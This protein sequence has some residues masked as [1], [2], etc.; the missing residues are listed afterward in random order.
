MPALSPTM[1]TGNIGKWLKNEGDKINAGDLLVEVQT[2]KSTLE[3]EFPEEGYLAKILTPNGSK[4]V[5]LGSPI[6]ILVDDASKISSVQ[7]ITLADLGASSGASATSAPS[8][9]PSTTPSTPSTPT[10]ST[11]SQKPKGVHEITMPMLSPTMTKGRIGSWVKQVGDKVSPGD[12]ICTV[13]TDKATVDFEFQEEGYLAKIVAPQGT[14]TSLGEVIAILV[15]KKEDL[16]TGASYTPSAATAAPSTQQQ[17]QPQQQQQPQSQPQVQPQQPTSIQQGATGGRIFASPLAK[18]VAAEKG[19]DLREIGSGSGD[20]GRIIRAD[21]EE[22]LMRKPTIQEQPK[23]AAVVAQPQV[24]QAGVPTASYVDIPVSTI[25]KVIAER[26]TESKR[27]IPHYYLTVEIEVDKLLKAREEL[28][29][30]GEKR[31]FK[32]SVNDMLVKAAALAMKKAPEV[33]SSW[34][35]SFIRQYN[36]VDVSVAVQTDN[37]LITPIV[38]SAESKGLAQI[39]NEIKALAAKARENKLK[40]QEFQGGTFTI[41]NLGMFGIDEFSAIINPPQACILAVGKSQKKVVVNDNPTSP[42]DKFKVVTTMK[43]TLSCD[44]RVVDG[45]VGAQWLQEFKTLLE[46]PLYMTL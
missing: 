11:T 18:K 6:G 16:A 7:N 3:F 39:S 23:V 9:T 34:N 1:T 13:E 17:A 37:G 19:V 35:D 20:S 12:I 15:D 14:E 22:F 30:A 41:S 31:G 46:N 29:K 10:T 40:P 25:R 42:E 28:N 33:N 5:A 26:L 38:F 2:D 27:N 21:V 45:A 44:H 4:D 36:N 43:V 8:K 24:M 32:L